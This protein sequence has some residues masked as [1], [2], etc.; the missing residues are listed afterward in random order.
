MFCMGGDIKSLR[1]FEAQSQNQYIFVR[2]KDEA[3]LCK[4]KQDVRNYSPVH[5]VINPLLI[6][7]PS[8]INT[9]RINGWL[10][11]V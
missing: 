4:C 5:H 10:N 2:N 1:F 6:I 3:M 9:T 11:I 7:F 8:A